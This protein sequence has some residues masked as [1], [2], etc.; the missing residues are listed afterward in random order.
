MAGLA[1][2]STVAEIPNLAASAGRIAFDGG[3][4]DRD[5][6]VL[7]TGRI[8]LQ[9]RDIFPASGD[10]AVVE[11][12]RGQMTRTYQ[13]VI[14][15]AAL[16]QIGLFV[17]AGALKGVNGIAAARQHERMAFEHDAKKAAVPECVA[18]GNC[19][20]AGPIGRGGRGQFC[21]L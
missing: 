19:D 15:N 5:V 17:R 10:R 3:R 21:F 18:S 12:K 9:R 13:P 4:I 14:F 2:A 11:R 7:D 20:E 8:K 6:I 16:R 1:P